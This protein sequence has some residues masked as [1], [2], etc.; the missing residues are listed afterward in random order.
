MY[1]QVI[2]FYLKKIIPSIS[3]CNLVVLKMHHLWH[4]GLTSKSSSGGGG[5]RM[6]RYWLWWQVLK[7]IVRWKFSIIFSNT[8][9]FEIF[10]NNKIFFNWGNYTIMD[11]TVSHQ[12]SYVDPN[13]HDLTCDLIW[14]EAL[15][16]SNQ[17][18]LIS[19][20]C[21]LIQLDWYPYQKGTFGPSLR[22]QVRETTG[23]DGHLYAKES[24]GTDALLTALRRNQSCQCLDFGLLVSRTVR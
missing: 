7:L 8:F 23:E 2:W 20:Q 17:V 14:R 4:L 3:F 24:P 10:H 15:Y 6:K 18:K 5:V 11:W 9:M 13:S 1:T 19:F 21:P 16:R 22:G 12:N